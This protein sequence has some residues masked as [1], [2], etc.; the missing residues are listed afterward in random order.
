MHG[1]CHAMQSFMVARST[2]TRSPYPVV[3]AQMSRHYVMYE[4]FFFPGARAR[5]GSTFH[6]LCHACFFCHLSRVNFHIFCSRVNVIANCPQNPRSK[7]S[8]LIFYKKKTKTSAGVSSINFMIILY[9][10]PHRMTIVG[11]RGRVELEGQTN[12]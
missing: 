6:E 11:L 5:L 2:G 4:F 3:R 7:C 12:Y 8:M 10:Q 9:V 1:S